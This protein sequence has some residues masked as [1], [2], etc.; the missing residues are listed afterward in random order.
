[1]SN[2]NDSQVKRVRVLRWCIAG[3]A[4]W[5]VL[6]LM[7]WSAFFYPDFIKFNWFESAPEKTNVIAQFPE[8]VPETAP[9]V[10]Q[11][12][13]NEE[14]PSS[15]EITRR[16]SLLEKV[17]NYNGLKDYEVKSK[18]L[19]DEPFS[20]V[21]VSV[22]NTGKKITSFESYS[23]PVLVYVQEDNLYFARY[24]S[25]IGGWCRGDFFVKN[26][27]TGKEKIIIEETADFWRTQDGKN[28]IILQYEDDFETAHYYT[29]NFE[30]QKLINQG[31][32]VKCGG[33]TNI[34]LGCYDVFTQYNGKILYLPVGY[35][36]QKDTTAYIFSD[37]VETPA[38]K[39][40]NQDS[41]NIN[42]DKLLQKVYPI[43]NIPSS[44][45]Q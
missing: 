3:V 31:V 26:I 41:S 37:N 11:N 38:T 28:L 34:Q 19:S 5:G 29:Y 43:L 21:Q 6:L 36:N 2:K 39:I 4:V 8:P 32:T 33:N 45:G 20:N 10:N 23:V 18:D 35:S 40:E 16:E 15:P 22:F 17:G 7:A 30:S 9:V 14:N 44:I 27:K 24:C 13:D 25:G 42:T 12:D 1:M